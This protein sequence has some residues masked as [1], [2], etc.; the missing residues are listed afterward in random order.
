MKGDTR[1]LDYGPFRLQAFKLR[2]LDLGAPRVRDQGLGFLGW[3]FGVKVRGFGF[4]VSE[5]QFRF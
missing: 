4:K 5:F 2:D 1:G 3:G